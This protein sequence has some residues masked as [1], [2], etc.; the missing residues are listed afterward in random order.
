[1]IFAMV[2]SL[3][4]PVPLNRDDHG[5]WRVTGTRLTLD[6]V[7]KE[8]WQGCSAEQFVDAH[9]DIELSQVYAI[10]SWYLSNR[11][12]VDA[13]LRERER[14]AGELREKVL[15]REPRALVLERLSKTTPSRGG[16]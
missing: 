2:A 5:V 1:M 10:L 13:Y 16:G 9:P 15:S 8:F 4:Q 11:E 12:Q 14:E 6:V 3:S 7:V